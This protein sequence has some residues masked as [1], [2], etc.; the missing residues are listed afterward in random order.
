MQLVEQHIRSWLESFV[1]GL[2]LCPFAAGVLDSPEL[3]ITVSNAQAA[4]DVRMEFLRELEVLVRS[5]EEEVATLLLVFP[6]A[7]GE[8]EDYLDFL[9]EAQALVVAAGLD[10]LVQLASFHPRYQFEGEEPES[11][12]N[13]SNR[14]PYPVLH[15]LRENMLTRVLEG[16]PEPELIPKRNIRTLNDLGLPAVE[17]RWRALLLPRQD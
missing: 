6:D 7:L 8:F 17:Q 13:Y 3:R 11:P 12:S 14:S 1:V 15:L 10:G 2:N 9:D 5:S 16:F 4:D